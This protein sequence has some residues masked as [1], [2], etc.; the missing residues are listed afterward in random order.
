[1]ETDIIRLPEGLSQRVGRVEAA[2]SGIQRIVSAPGGAAGMGSHAFIH[3]ALGDTADCNLV[4]IGFTGGVYHKRNINT[5]K[6]TAIQ[7]FALA[8]E[9]FDLSLLFQ[10]GTVFDLQQLLC[11]YSAQAD[12]AAKLIQDTGHLEGGRDTEQSR[13]LGVVAA[14]VNSTCHGVGIRMCGTNDRVQLTEDHDLGTLSAGIQHGIKA[15]DTVR[16]SQFI[17]QRTELLGHIRRGLDLAITRLGMRPDPTLGSKNQLSVLF[18]GVYN[19][20]HNIFPFI[21]YVL[22]HRL[23]CFKISLSEYAQRGGIKMQTIFLERQSIRGDN[24]TVRYTPCNLGKIL[25]HRAKILT[26]IVFGIDQQRKLTNDNGYI[27]RIQIAAQGRDHFN[28]AIGIRAYPLLTQAIALT[29]MPKDS[30]QA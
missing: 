13:T 6:I 21:S 5:V 27:F 7:E 14:G 8:A 2:G 19:V 24:G 16:H 29:L 17:A 25:I 12:S 1:M 3:D 20:L 11:R 15:G 18:N 26:S 10:L 28:K 30:A 22:H 4:D 9:I 23:I